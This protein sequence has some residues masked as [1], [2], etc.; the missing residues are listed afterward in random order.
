MIDILYVV[1]SILFF[2][3]MLAYTAACSRLGRVG[4]VDRVWED[5]R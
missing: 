2:S 5:V 4:E 1:G 3:L